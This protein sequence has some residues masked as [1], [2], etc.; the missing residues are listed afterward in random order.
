MIL[1]VENFDM[2]IRDVFTEDGAE[3][4]LRK[5]MTRR[6]N[7]VMLFVTATGHVD[8]EYDRPPSN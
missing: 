8:M 5:W 1:V 4:R 6:D 7:R 2:L 3:E